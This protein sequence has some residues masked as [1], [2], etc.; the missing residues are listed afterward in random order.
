ML[1]A[2]QDLVAGNAYTYKIP[3]VR[4]QVDTHTS[5][6]YKLSTMLV[7]NKDQR[8][9]T[10]EEFV[11]L[12]HAYIDPVHTD[13]TAANFKLQSAND[14]VQQTTMDLAVMFNYNI[15]APQRILLKWNNNNLGILRSQLLGISI[16]GCKVE[17]F[18]KIYLIMITP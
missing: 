13:M 18:D 16:S 9:F 11:F 4:N 12:N 6:S 3:M 5:I 17:V 14:Y 2:G 10:M 1:V 15:A 8:V 7:R